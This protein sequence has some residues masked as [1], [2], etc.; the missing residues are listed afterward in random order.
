MSPTKKPSKPKTPRLPNL[1]PEQQRIMRRTIEYTKTV[2][3]NPW[4]VNAIPVT[5]QTPN[6]NRPHPKQRVFLY[7]SDVFEVLYGG[8]AGGGKTSAALMAAAQY[9]DV[10]G[11]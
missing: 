4:I 2:D 3:R 1:S 9:V 8:A 11:Y 7:L 5:D 6:G 10:P